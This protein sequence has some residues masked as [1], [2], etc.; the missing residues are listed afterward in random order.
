MKK[1]TVTKGSKVAIALLPFVLVGCL[2]TPPRVAQL[3]DDGKEIALQLSTNDKSLLGTRPVKEAKDA[4]DALEKGDKNSV[5][6]LNSIAELHVLANDADTAEKKARA[7]LKRDIK[8]VD[9]A[10]TLI[11]VAI[12]KR[13][14]EEAKLITQN[15]LQMEPRNTDLLSL[16]GLCY[17]YTGEVIEAREAW[18]KALTIDSRH[19]ASQMNL[20]VLYYMNRN[21]S[22]ADAMFER[23]L[24]IQPKNGDAAVGHALVQSA[25]GKAE[26]ARK[27]LQAMLETFSES[28]LVLY[29]LAVIEKERFQNFESSLS[30]LNKYLAVAKGER[31]L[32]ERAL[33]M[34][35]D[36]KNRIAELEKGSLSDKDLRQLA[37]KSSQAASREG[38]SGETKS[39][40]PV[41]KNNP[42]RVQE[43]KKVE[44][45]SKAVKSQKNNDFLKDDVQSLE[46][47]LK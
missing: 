37:D 14:Y 36:V 39:S 1:N 11:K 22:L 17:F 3:S 32:M 16:K 45:H 5:A 30:Y 12:L 31:G 10:K 18:K 33:A 7:I 20:G 27:T 25:Q 43:T 2:S 34:K 23:V 4:I 13:K 29:N 26:A 35:E 40:A 6:I 47:D 42:E 21:L 38:E 46:E 41:A 19:V 28:P 24:K 9:A 8:N 44:E 15:A